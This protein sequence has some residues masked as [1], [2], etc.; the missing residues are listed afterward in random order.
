[1]LCSCS[2]FFEPCCGEHLLAD[3]DFDGIT[4]ANLHPPELYLARWTFSAEAGQNLLTA[5]ENDGFVGPGEECRSSVVET[6]AGDLAFFE[7]SPVPIDAAPGEP[8]FGLL[9]EVFWTPRED[10]GGPAQYLSR[11]VT[12]SPVALDAHAQCCSTVLSLLDHLGRGRGIV[13]HAWN[14]LEDA[15]TRP[16]FKE[17]GFHFRPSWELLNAAAED[18]TSFVAILATQ[19]M[20]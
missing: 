20:D 3:A 7:L 2:G 6:R 10:R 17:E 13:H 8:G 14:L 11:C 19:K 15:A 12:L 9:L 5:I 4:E 16:P 1:M 18:P